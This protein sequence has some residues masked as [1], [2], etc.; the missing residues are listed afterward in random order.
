MPETLGDILPPPP[1]KLAKEAMDGVK[2]A[3]I[4]V[5]NDIKNVADDAKNAVVEM[6]PHNLIKGSSPKDMLPPP[7]P[8]PPKPPKLSD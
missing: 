7:P 1:H 2:L 6:A 8:K 5:K 4:D 3:A